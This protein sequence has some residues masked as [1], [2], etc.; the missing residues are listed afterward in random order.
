[1]GSGKGGGH[2]NIRGGGGG[3]DRIGSLQFDW[4]L[5]FS[6]IIA[7]P[8]LCSIPDTWSGSHVL[9]VSGIYAGAGGERGE[10]GGGLSLGG[11]CFWCRCAVSRGGGGGGVNGGFQNF[12]LNKMLKKTR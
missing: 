11:G 2:E 10:G 6:S 4:R 7:L 5:V 12:K 8:S 1:M 9:L 3:H